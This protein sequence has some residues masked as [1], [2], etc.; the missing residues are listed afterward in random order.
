MRETVLKNC[1][2]FH[3]TFDFNSTFDFTIGGS[4]TTAARGNDNQK[5]HFVRPYEK[6]AKVVLHDNA[7]NILFNRKMSVMMEILPSTVPSL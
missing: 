5:S 4:P 1:K 6:K 2:N 3:K 7:N